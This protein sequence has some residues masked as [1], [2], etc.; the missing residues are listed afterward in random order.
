MV[1]LGWA[2]S[3]YKRVKRSINPLFFTVQM[4]RACGRVDL[5]LILAA[6]VD[7]DSKVRPFKN[8]ASPGHAWFLLPHLFP[9]SW[10]NRAMA[11]F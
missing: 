8:V 10:L 2:L 1:D 4:V 6:Q 11:R 3:I 5:Y 7:V 9:V